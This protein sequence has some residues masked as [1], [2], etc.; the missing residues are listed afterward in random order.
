MFVLSV[1]KYGLLSFYL[2][3]GSCLWLMMLLIFRFFFKHA[4]KILL[5]SDTWGLG[6]DLACL[7]LCGAFGFFV[8]CWCYPIPLSL[9]CS[10]SVELSYCCRLVFFMSVF[11][12]FSRVVF[13]F[14]CGRE[15]GEQAKQ[16]RMKK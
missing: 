7:V 3:G 8:G 9:C 1:Q 15:R 14:F 6:S 10:F 11:S 16:R 5:C 2:T 12:T 4:Q 13:F